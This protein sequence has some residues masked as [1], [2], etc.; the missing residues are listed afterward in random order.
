[1][2]FNEKQFKNNINVRGVLFNYSIKK[3]AEAKRMFDREGF[4]K[5]GDKF[6]EYRGFVDILTNVETGSYVRVNVQSEYKTY[7]SGANQ[8]KATALTE[9]LEAMANKEIETLM[10][11]SV[12]LVKLKKHQLFQFG[13]VSHTT[14]NS[15]TTSTSKM[16]N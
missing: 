14:L 3:D 13:D 16:E 9:A 2:A 8:G 6:T 7:N 1:M 10:K 15:V 12:R 5:K 4:F 11:Q